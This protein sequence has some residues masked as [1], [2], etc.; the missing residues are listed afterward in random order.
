VVGA[1]LRGN[2][3]GDNGDGVGAVWVVVHDNRGV[4]VM[5]GGRLAWTLATTPLNQ[6]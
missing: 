5:S 2:G 1:S 6:R 4:G 3:R